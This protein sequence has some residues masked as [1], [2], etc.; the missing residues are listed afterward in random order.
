MSSMSNKDEL[1]MVMVKVQ[2]RDV[3][4]GRDGGGICALYPVTP[5]TYPFR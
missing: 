4:A 2:W 1:L 3:N 5:E